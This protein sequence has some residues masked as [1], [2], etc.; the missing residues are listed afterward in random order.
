MWVCAGCSLA[1]TACSL[2]FPLLLSGALSSFVCVLI[3]RY[4]CSGVI[5]YLMTAFKE[6]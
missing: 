2:S 6:D 3:Q 5:N 4:T 1:P